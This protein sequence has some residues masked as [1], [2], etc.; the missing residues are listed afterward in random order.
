VG[1][2][3]TITEM[4]FPVDEN[5]LEAAERALGHRLP[6]DLRRR[7]RRDNGGEVTAIP[8]QEGAGED[9]DP[10]WHLF[11]VWDDSDRRRAKRT[12]GHI[13]RETSEA[14]SWPGFPSD[15]VAVADNGTGDRLIMRDGDAA[16]WDHETGETHPV[17]VDWDR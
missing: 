6:Q 4:G 14:R 17:R 7:L 16:W 9:V 8:L 13:V 12:A 2:R 1:Y 11:P 5:R 3:T 10:Y 15:A